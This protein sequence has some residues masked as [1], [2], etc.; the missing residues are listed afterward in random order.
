[1]MSL[2]K[3]TFSDV[4]NLLLW[5]NDSLTRANSRDTGPKDLSWIEAKLKDPKTILLIG[6]VDGHPVGTATLDDLSTTLELSWTVSPDKRGLGYGTALVRSVIDYH[7]GLGV[8]KILSAQIKINNKPSIRIAKSVG[9]RPGQ[10]DGELQTW[11]Y[12]L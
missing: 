11:S 1:M 8:R 6:E 9:F 10:V 12:V 2:R 3:A 4:D 7:R 5:R